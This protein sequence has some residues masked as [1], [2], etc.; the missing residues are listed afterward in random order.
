MWEGGLEQIKRHIRLK[1]Q[2]MLTYMTEG[3][4]VYVHVI[5]GI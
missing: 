2:M 3:Y 1:F 5:R 4:S